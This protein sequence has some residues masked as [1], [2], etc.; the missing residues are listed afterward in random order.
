MNILVRI[1]NKSF[2]VTIIPAA[3][4]LIQVILR[5]FGVEFDFTDI[6]QKIIDVVNAA[7]GFLVVLGV[8]SDP[9]TKGFKDSSQAMKYTAPKED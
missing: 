1:K 9:T 5:L 7:F 6:E 2:W 3:L 8:A 4:L